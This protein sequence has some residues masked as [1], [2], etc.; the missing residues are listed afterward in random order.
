[1]NEQREITE[2]SRF[3]WNAGAAY[4]S[5]GFVSL[6]QNSSMLGLRRE[7]GSVQGSS[8]NRLSEQQTTT[9][10]RFLAALLSEHLCAVRVGW[11]VGINS[12]F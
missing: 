3:E 12:M 6:W 9:A 7:S 4:S 5:N 8:V 2:R 11:Q 1:M 10:G